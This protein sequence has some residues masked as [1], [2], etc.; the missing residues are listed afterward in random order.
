MFFFV[1][2]IW[3]QFEI[4]PT[5]WIFHFIFL[6]KK[7]F[8]HCCS[9]KTAMTIA[10]SLSQ[11]PYKFTVCFFRQNN[12]IDCWYRPIFAYKTNQNN[13]W[14]IV[15]KIFR[16]KFSEPNQSKSIFHFGCGDLN[17]YRFFVS[18]Q[19]FRYISAKSNI[20]LCNLYVMFEQKLYNKIAIMHTIR[21]T[22]IEFI[23][24]KWNSSMVLNLA[25]AYYPLYYNCRN[26]SFEHIPKICV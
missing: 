17:L 15:N 20:C 14:S 6:I 2:V 18:I 16:L 3:W 8:L 21:K 9:S 23:N 12:S 13:V 4:E 24:H 19:C 26:I 5:G 1:H 25:C 10:L 7:K 22:V 11:A